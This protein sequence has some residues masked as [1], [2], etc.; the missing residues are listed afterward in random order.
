MTHFLS[1]PPEVRNMIYEY[2]LVVQR[3]IVPIPPVYDDTRLDLASQF[4]GDAESRNQKPSLSLLRVNKQI[5]IETEPIFYG[6]NIWCME[7]PWHLEQKAAFMRNLTVSLD[8]RDLC[9]D[10]VADDL[11]DPDNLFGK[12]YQAGGLGDPLDRMLLVHDDRVD[13]LIHC[14]W[15]SKINALSQMD[16]DTLIIDIKR[17]W[18]FHGCCRLI[19]QLD[20]TAVEARKITIIGIYNQEEASIMRRKFPSGLLTEFKDDSDHT[21]VIED[22]S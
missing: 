6:Q 19:D 10:W 20:M 22:L 11:D 3:Q 7:T 2:C 8:F 4:T 13:S 12:P 16:L 5:N 15:E 18:C 17:C 1:L 9:L 21:I 14:E